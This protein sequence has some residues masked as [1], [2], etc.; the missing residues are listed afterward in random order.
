V[1]PH[2]FAVGDVLEGV[3]SQH[4]RGVAQHLELARAWGTFAEVIFDAAALIRR[5]LV[6]EVGA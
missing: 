3:V 5:E 1:Q 2:P 4:V 6:V